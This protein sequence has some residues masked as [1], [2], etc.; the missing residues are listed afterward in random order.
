MANSAVFCG[1]DVSKDH[2]DVALLP[3]DECWTIGNDP[4]AIQELVERL[5]QA[6][7]GLTVMKRPAASRER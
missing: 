6:G 2:L 1:I 4:A 7:P 3:S 5:K